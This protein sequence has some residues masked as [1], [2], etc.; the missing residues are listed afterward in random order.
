V[1]PH[2][3]ES[4]QA[5][6]STTSPS[7]AD[8][9]GY[10]YDYD[11]SPRVWLGASMPDG[12]G[13]RVGYWLYDQA[14]PPVQ[15]QSDADQ[16]VGA[17]T[18]TGSLPAIIQSTGA[19]QILTAS[20]GLEVETIDFEGT[21][22]M[23]LGQ[24]QILAGAGIRYGRMWQNN[25]AVITDGGMPQSQLFRSR[26]FK[27]LGPTLNGDIVR[28]V[29]N[30]GLAIATGLRGAL[31]F[32]SKSIVR[33]STGNL[34]GSP[35]AAYLDGV[36]DFTFTADIGVGLQWTRTVSGMDVSLRGGYEGSFWIDAGEPV[37]TLL[38]FEGF[39]LALAVMR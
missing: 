36:D 12:L 6:N 29:G 24:T 8:L 15:L 13:F 39:T 27:G 26:E 23:E 10:N 1:K 22:Q 31:L 5:T 11:L 34:A 38:G 17:Q 25:L 16:T 18:I 35:D 3:K 30:S 4:F 19:G 7:A 14:G 37:L 20:S 21:M 9:V 32:G 2:F 33:E 28:P